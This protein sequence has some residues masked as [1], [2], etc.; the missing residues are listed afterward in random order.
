MDANPILAEQTRGGFV[1]NRHRGAIVVR[2]ASGR[3]IASAGDTARPVFPRSA[4]KSLQALP[5]FTTGAVE[6][7]GLGAADLALAC[8]SHHG[9]AAHVA[10]VTAFLGRLGLDAAALECGAHQPTN[11]E[12]RQAL[13]EAGMKP[14]PL[15]NNCSGKHAGMLASARA[16][17]VP[18]AGY[19]EAGHPVQV[20]VRR[21]IEAVTGAPLHEDRCGT[22]G[23][24][25]P[26]WATPLNALALG[27]ARL[28]TGRD[29]PP[30]LA[31]GAERLME[32]ATGQ[33]HLVAGTGHF[34]TRVM[35]AFGGRVMHKG[36]AEGVQCG[37]IRDKGWG[38]AI[39]CDDGNMAASLAMAAEMLLALAEPDDGQAQMLA[40]FAVQEVRN[41]RRRAV[42]EMRGTEM[43]RA[44]V[45]ARN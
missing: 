37:A 20:E 16:M 12:A 22:D 29:L 27:F 38:Y 13:R 34:D 10:G 42:G 21:V 32:A 23:C 6:R 14:G 24:S 3:V 9:E 2:D 28:A 8:A 15:H 33:P 1:E 17:D 19:V 7:F 44:A 43:L 31:A 45:R 30:K 18:V 25:V 4:I 35:E 40:E 41:V 39:K 11:A 36:G 26:T 5:L